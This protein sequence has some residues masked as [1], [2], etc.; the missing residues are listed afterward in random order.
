MSNIVK[1]ETS[2]NYISLTT[3]EMNT[4]QV[5]QPLTNVIEI[6]TG[7]MG[8]PGAPGTSST[9]IFTHI[10]GN[11]YTTTNDLAFLGSVNVSG[12]LMVNN[13]IVLTNSNFIDKEVPSGFI[14]GFN[15][16]FTLSHLPVPGSE[17]VFLNGMLQD[18]EDDYAISGSSITF[19]VIPMPFPHSNIKCSYRTM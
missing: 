6:L 14:D 5:V 10:S 2:F 19:F 15:D 18:Q 12:S 3:E 16:T 1:D 9:S 7:P 11:L 4:V 8:P 17:H 13:Y